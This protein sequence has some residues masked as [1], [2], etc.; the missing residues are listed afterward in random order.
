VTAQTR[1]ALAA[2]HVQRSAGHVSAERRRHERDLVLLYQRDPSTHATVIAAFRPLAHGIAKRYFRGGEPLEDLEQVALLGLVKALERFDPDRGSPFATYAI[3]T[4]AG[5]VRRHY[6]DAGWAVHVARADQELAQRIAA[7]ERSSPDR[8]STE[9]IAERLGLT[10]EQVV[11][12]RLV[13]RAMHADSLDRPHRDEETPAFAPATVELGYASVEHRAT[14]G[15]LTA[16]LP[17]RERAI[18]ALRYAGDLSQ[19]EIGARVGVSQ[20][21]VSRILRR[22]LARLAPEDVEAVGP[23][24]C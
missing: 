16:D 3:P 8:L 4:I 7:L 10:L 12:G 5:E 23:A 2:R 1:A 11:S 22:T 21:H 17:E 13:Q 18:L 6:R 14:I 9:E 24:S 19:A 15:R 20:M